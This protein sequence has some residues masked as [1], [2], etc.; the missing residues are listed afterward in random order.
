MVRRHGWQLP[1]HPFQVGAITVFFLLVVAYYAFFAPFLGGRILEYASMAVYTPVVLAVFYLYV[2]CTAINPA[3]PGILARFDVKLMMDSDNNIGFQGLELHGNLGEGADTSEIHNSPSSASK[4][5]IT[6][7]TS[8]KASLGEAGGVNIPK[9]TEGKRSRFFFSI[10][11]LFCALFTK[12]DCHKREEITELQAANAEDALFCTLCNAEVRKFSKH[13]KCCDKC[14][15]GFDHHC[16]WLNNCVGR[17]NYM[18]FISLM[19]ASLIWLAIECGVGIAVLVLCFVDR[20]ATEDRIV[21]RLGNGFSRAPFVTVVVICSAVSLL[22]CVPLGE[23]FFFHMILIR[24]GI[25]TYEY[26]VAMRAMS[27]APAGSIDD[28]NQNVIYSPSGSATTGFSGGSSLGLQYKGAWCTPPRVFVDHQ[29]EV[30]PHLDPRMVPSTVDPD[31]A[32]F[33]DKGKLPRRHVPISAWK[34][35]KLDSNEV[36]IAAAKARASSSVL[37]PVDTRRLPDADISSS[38]NMSGRSSIST[39]FGANKELKIDLKL[40]P[41]GH[42]YP[43]SHASKDDYETGTQSMS[44]FSSPSRVHDSVALSPLPL[45]NRSRPSNAMNVATHLQRSLPDRPFTTR[46]TLHNTNLSNPIFQSATAGFDD[47]IMQKNTADA[48]LLSGQPG[49]R[50]SVIWDQEAGRYVSIPVS[51]RTESA[52]EN[53]AR[54][55]FQLPVVKPSAEPS[56]SVT[57]TTLKDSCTPKAPVQQSEK[58][59]YT[60][61]SIFFGGPLLSVPVQDSTRNRTT[62][63]RLRLDQERISNVLPRESRVGRGAKSSQFP[64]FTPGSS[65][66]NPSS[67]MK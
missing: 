12:E 67:N 29:D 24:K 32:G 22:A 59:L 9:G 37:R 28:D 33:T 60:G 45:E 7:N 21:E 64:V 10:G 50:T 44:S 15:D 53:P 51:S 61:Q 16:R 40:S 5:S 26:V 13:C 31:A 55:L 54:N 34:L 56:T 35:A 42:S 66:K 48:L 58:L 57:K 47:R 52:L 6:G 2:R 20:K 19:A 38:G 36:M 14:V 62:E 1:A 25:T 63:V 4:S 30:V 65:Q 46:T 23:L 8:K 39:D 41:L 17:K 49:K 3:D 27:E 43:T 18:S 11:G